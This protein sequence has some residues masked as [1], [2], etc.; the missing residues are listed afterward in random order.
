MGIAVAVPVLQLA[1]TLA[2]WHA[3]LHRP[4]WV[5][6]FTSFALNNLAKLPHGLWKPWA[7][8]VF[9][10][11]AV[12]VSGIENVLASI[13]A[14]ANAD[15]GSML[16]WGTRQGARERAALALLEVQEIREKRRVARNA[17]LACWLFANYSVGVLPFAL[18]IELIVLKFMYAFAAIHLMLNMTLGCC[19]SFWL[20]WTLTKASERQVSKSVSESEGLPSSH[21]KAVDCDP[22]SAEDGKGPL[23]TQGG[24]LNY[25]L[26]AA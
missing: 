21:V 19:Y 10:L 8:M 17:L 2:Y 20:Y 14:V 13:N 12:L 15:A 22:F 6:I 1:I 3:Y 23:L 18:G 7:G 25:N 24:K 26:L 11:I 16:G 5:I 9:P 4:F